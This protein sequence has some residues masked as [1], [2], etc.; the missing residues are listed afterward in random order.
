MMKTDREG[1]DKGS[2]CCE[3]SVEENNNNNNNNIVSLS[4]ERER[5]RE[6]LPGAEAL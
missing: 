1:R 4:R 5:E 6:L 3:V 2:S